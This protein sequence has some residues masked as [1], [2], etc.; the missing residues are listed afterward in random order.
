M[1]LQQN[2]SISANNV[3]QE[4]GLSGNTQHS[5]QAAHTGTGT[6]SGL[7]G[8]SP[9]GPNGSA[10]HSLSE[11]YG[12]DHDFQTENTEN[13]VQQ[14][15]TTQQVFT[16]QVV[17]TVNVNSC[18]VEGQKVRLSSGLL[19]NIERLQRGD[20][21]LGYA[22]E[23]MPMDHNVTDEWKIT[24]LTNVRIK[25][26]PVQ[27]IS[28]TSGTNPLYI[29]I[30]RNIK[31]NI[32]LTQEHPLF[33]KRKVDQTYTYRWM[34][35]DE[36][37]VNDYMLCAN[38]FDKHDVVWKQSQ[39]KDWILIENKH[40][41]KEKCIAYSIDVNNTDTYVVGNI[42]VHNDINVGKGGDI[43]IDFDKF[44]G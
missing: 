21:L 17:N 37:E 11:F 26:H 35:A 41:V 36:V 40:V 44:S 2:G 12:Y 13:T 30:N 10:P 28:I 3:N 9:S 23:D 33:I 39:D 1:A 20:E 14:V 5:F 42:V 43:A 19:M 27:I 34:R 7:N 8:G 25:P 24:V 18:I 38:Y 31:D 29:D 15:P 22:I 4:F 16:T 32:K 6:F